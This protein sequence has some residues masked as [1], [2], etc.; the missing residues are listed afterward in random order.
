MVSTVTGA[1]DLPAA[2]ISI[3]VLAQLASALFNERLGSGSVP[4][5]VLED[6]VDGWIAAGGG[7]PTA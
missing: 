4:L 1:P 5:D 3:D 6:Q 7:A 2:P